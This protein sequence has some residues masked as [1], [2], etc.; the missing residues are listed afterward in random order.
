MS[1]KCQFIFF[2][3]VENNFSPGSV[4][5]KKGIEIPFDNI[6]IKK[7]GKAFLSCILL[8]LVI[9]K[10]RYAG[11]RIGF[12]RFRLCA[13][14]AYFFFLNRLSALSMTDSFSFVS[15]PFSSFP[16]T[17]PF[18]ACSAAFLARL[19]MSMP[20]LGEVKVPPMVMSTVPSFEP[21]PPEGKVILPV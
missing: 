19:A 2:Y 4:I 1:A 17:S 5:R 15:S 13:R 9:R 10:S 21:I 6:S 16:F 14:L 20:T 11:M 12:C 3:M 7:D 18:K 8:K